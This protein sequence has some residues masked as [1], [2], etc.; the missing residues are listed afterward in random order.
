MNKTEDELY[1][2][3]LSND[4]ILEENRVGALLQQKDNLIYFQITNLFKDKQEIKYRNLKDLN[5]DPPKLVINA[6][7]GREVTFDLT[8]ETTRTLYESLWEAQKAYLGYK[9][10][11]EKKQNFKEYIKDLPNKIKKHPI[12]WGLA[13]LSLIIIIYVLR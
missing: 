12:H 13:I 10:H 1:L 5:D 3:E 2:E 4:T 9:Y 11:T 6:S 7:D 8:K